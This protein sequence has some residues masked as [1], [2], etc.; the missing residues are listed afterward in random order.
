MGKLQAHSEFSK[1]TTR[2][3]VVARPAFPEF[4][5]EQFRSYPATGRPH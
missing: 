3:F 4:V 2:L 5:V 1:T